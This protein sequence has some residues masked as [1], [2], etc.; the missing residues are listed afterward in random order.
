MTLF[1]IFLLLLPKDYDAA[2]PPKRID[3][4]RT[5][6]PEHLQENSPD[7]SHFNHS[8]EQSTRIHT[9]LVGSPL[10]MQPSSP[11]VRERDTS[12]QKVETQIKTPLMIKKEKHRTRTRRYRARIKQRKQEG[13]MTDQDV[14]YYKGIRD[15][16]QNY[17]RKNPQ[18][19]PS[20]RKNWRKNN[21]EKITASRKSWS[22]RNSEKILEYRKRHKEKKLKLQS[23]QHA[24]EEEEVEDPAAV[25]G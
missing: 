13:K 22:E 21:K 5:P 17:D 23:K 1:G 10:R 25:K 12:N 18:V 2:R 4:N 15:R 24:E 3:L 7:V 8:D 11:T 16:W 14:R 9:L 20:S 6:S 19:A